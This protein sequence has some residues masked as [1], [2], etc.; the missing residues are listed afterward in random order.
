MYGLGMTSIEPCKLSLGTDKKIMM[1]VNAAILV[2]IAKGIFCTPMLIPTSLFG[3]KEV[4]ITGTTPTQR[5]TTK[6]S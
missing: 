3:H 5:A 2:Q 1:N 4:A 6:Y